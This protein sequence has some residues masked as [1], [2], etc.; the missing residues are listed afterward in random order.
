M[1]VTHIFNRSQMKKRRQILRRGMPYAELKLWSRLRR[2]ALDGH[3]F[4][5]Q[6]IIGSYVVDSYS[7]S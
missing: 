1:K 4:R 3:R 7:P 5:R 6:Y 2:R